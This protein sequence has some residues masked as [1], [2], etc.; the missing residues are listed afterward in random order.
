MN[1]TSAA[2]LFSAAF[3]VL[4][5]AAA[6]RPAGSWGLALLVLT[7]GAL[8]AAVFVRPAAVL[9]VL[10]TVAGMALA[11]PIPL[12]AAVS[13]LAAAAYLVSRFADDAATLTVPTVL[14]MVGFTLAGA[15][16]AAVPVQITWVPLVTPLIMVGILILVAAPLVTDV[17]SGPASE[18]EPPG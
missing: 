11:E 16:A 10:L 6:A 3:G 4:M 18:H 9:A 12:L 17:M 13:G 14:G 7:A 1:R 15:A 2:P 5:V 8:L